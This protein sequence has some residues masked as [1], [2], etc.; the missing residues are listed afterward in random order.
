LNQIIRTIKVKKQ[1]YG[2]KY[3]TQLYK[4]KEW[5]MLHFIGL[6]DVEEFCIDR[7]LLHDY[8]LSEPEPDNYRDDMF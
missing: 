6:D 5:I 8:Y 2:F 3:N 7:E 1:A 4:V